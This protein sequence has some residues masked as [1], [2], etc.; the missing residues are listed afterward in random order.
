MP[1]K[2]DTCRHFKA[3]PADFC[4]S[5]EIGTIRAHS[6]MAMTVLWAARETCD[7]EHDGHFVY[8]EP[9]D[10]E[11]GASFPENKASHLVQ[12]TRTRTMRAAA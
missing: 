5:P 7:R 10:P 12:I 4:T 9:R 3:G 11:A 2:C 6:R 8:F 1:R